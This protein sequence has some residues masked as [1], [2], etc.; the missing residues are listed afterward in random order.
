MLLELLMVLGAAIIY[1]VS[2]LYF[3]PRFILLYEKAGITVNNYKERPLA[4]ALGL[5]MLVSLMAGLAWISGWQFLSNIGLIGI[6]HELGV[7]LRGTDIGLAFVAISMALL[8]VFDDVM[9]ENTRGLRGHLRSFQK[10][11]LT[12]GM[13]KLSAGSLVVVI[14][15][16]NLEAFGGYG[17]AMPFKG[18]QVLD[19]Y[20]ELTSGHLMAVEIIL[21]VIAFLV[22]LLWTN[23]MNLLDRRPGRALKVFWVTGLI[24]SF[25]G[26]AW[27]HEEVFLL[28]PLLI[29]P[30]LL[31]PVDL[32]ERAMLGDAGANLMGGVLGFFGVLMLPFP[33]LLVFGIAGLLLNLSGEL[34]S[35]TEVIERNRFLFF[36]DK[37][38]RI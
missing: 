38:G 36:L 11:W 31:L 14:V 22:V 19:Y 25:M 6:E 8:G 9:D 26:I 3:I 37:L 27:G 5:A 16:L 30:L 32:K 4:P 21:R 2:S 17:G 28:V 10:G 35:L 33:A 18:G 13:L 15:V 1:L 7:D 29:F 12:A 34:V 20:S 23:G 24:L